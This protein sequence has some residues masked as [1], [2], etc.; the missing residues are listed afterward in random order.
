MSRILVFNNV[1]QHIRIIGLEEIG[2]K[3][4][5]LQNETE[6]KFVAKDEL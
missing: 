1:L 4:L 3:M 2:Q 5:N 6:Q